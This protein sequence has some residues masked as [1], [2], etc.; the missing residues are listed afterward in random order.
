MND[1]HLVNPAEVA[2]RHASLI[3]IAVLLVAL[4]FGASAALH[5]TDGSLARAL[6]TAELVLALAAAALA[7][8]VLGWKAL[9]LS[10]ADRRAYFSEDG[11]A[12]E[13]L[14]QSRIASWNITFLLL[15]ALEIFA[16]NREGVPP[17]FF[18]QLALAVLLA[19]FGLKFFWVLRAADGSDDA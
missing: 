17:E 3:G 8:W 6:D 11:F 10:P 2:D 4:K 15:I 1:P 5:F 16:G 9:R 13:A 18:L 12:F 19:A 7:L 14:R